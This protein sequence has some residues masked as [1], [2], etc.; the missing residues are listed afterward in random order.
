MALITADQ[1]RRA[2]PAGSAKTIAAI[3][4]NA[5]AVFTEYG[6]TTLN[7]VLGFLSVAVEETGG[8]VTLFEYMNYTAEQANKVFPNKF[9][10]VQSAIPFAHNPEAFANKVYDGWMGNA[11][12]S[13]DGWRYRG[14]GLIQITGHDNFDM[15]ANLTKLPLLDHPEL[16]TDDDHLLECAVVLFVR[17]PSILQ[18]C[19]AANWPYVW[20]LVGSGS[21]TG[22]IINLPAHETALASVKQ[23]ITALGRPDQPATV[24]APPVAAVAVKPPVAPVL[25][26]VA[27]TPPAAP[28]LAAVAAT[29]PAAPAGSEPLAATLNEI[30]ARLVRVE[31]A[32]AQLQRPA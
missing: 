27:A 8:F 28:V 4:S 31:S 25:A 16:V 30:L 5:D 12:N 22:R 13:D 26:A 20:A 9:P 10:T 29:P 19:D 11:A 7:R 21:R 3:V 14:Q 2:A 1:L 18:Y 32:I 6:L 15:L 23:A 17:Y 24:V